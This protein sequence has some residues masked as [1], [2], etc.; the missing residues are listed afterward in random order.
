MKSH[1]V[2]EYSSTSA[3]IPNE[4][5]RDFQMAWSLPH[6]LLKEVISSGPFAVTPGPVR[7]TVPGP[8][9]CFCYRLSMLSRWLQYSTSRLPVK[10]NRHRKTQHVS[11]P[12]YPPN[13]LTCAGSF[14]SLPGPQA[15]DVQGSKND[16]ANSSIP[17]YTIKR[18]PPR[19]ISPGKSTARRQK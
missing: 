13:G 18:R 2:L 12:K 9:R 14:F 5:I 8:F 15:K 19:W 1:S 17:N 10:V 11:P 16:G 6:L 7:N 3:A 4:R